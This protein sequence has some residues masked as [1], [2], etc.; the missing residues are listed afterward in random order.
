MTISS[1]TIER[2]NEE[3]QRIPLTEERAAELPVELGQLHAAVEAAR[4][5]HDFDRLPASF[6]QALHALRATEDGARAVGAAVEAGAGA[7]GEGGEIAALS[8]CEAADAVA[9]GDLS[10]T[11]LVEAALARI[12][13]LDPDLHAFVRLEREDALAKARATDRDRS[14]GG[15]AGPLAGVPLAHKDMYYRAGKVS[16]CGS[17]IRRDFWPDRTATVLDRL[18][19]AGAIDLGGLAM[20]EFAMGPH[21]FNAHL[22][23]CRNVWDF[24]R[25]P[26]GSSSGSGTA[27]AGRLVYAALGSD[28]GGSIRCP[29]AANGVA[30]IN[31]T[32]GRVSRF[33]CMP[34]SW[35]LDVMGPLAR[36]VQDCARVLGAIAGADENDASTSAEPVPDYEATIER[37]VRG[38]RI[39]IPAGY[40]DEDLDPGVAAVIEATH[41]VFKGL[42]ATLVPVAMPALLDTVSAIHPVLMKVEGAAN[43]LP[44]KR[45]HDADYS[46]EVGKRLQ[47]GFFI[48]ATD[49]INA[50]QY[51][52]HALRA[53]ADAVFGACDA[54]LTPVL[55]MPT[56]T[57]ADTAYRDGPAYLKMVVGLTRNT[58]VVNYLGLPA[59]SVTCGFTPCGMPTSFQLIGRPFA[60]A[61]LFR[62]GHQYQRE[63]DWH[64]RWPAALPG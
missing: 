21:G 50:L 52:A 34:M 3:C 45:A 59:L 12:D 32:M 47:A 54:L 57:L 63:T 49:Y 36:T 16:G 62:L 18:D 60:E 6:E 31:P 64:R 27:V 41:G 15:N 11:E 19:A 5:D 7:A 43:H 26:C 10:A 39:G 42:G 20:V 22:P 56:P 17:R 44:W 24:E 28:T 25:I 29:A 30:G 40:F 14:S 37:S 35:S 33:G 23:R 1:E 4:P 38:V 9:G 51:R 8:L 48:P 46:D 13:R 58:R 55:P 2:L 61:L 53:F